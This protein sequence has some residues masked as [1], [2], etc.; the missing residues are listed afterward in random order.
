MQID[1]RDV[2]FSR[3]GSYMSLSILPPSWNQPGVTL[4]SMRNSGGCKEVFNLEPIRDGQTVSCETRCTPGQLQLRDTAGNSVEMCYEDVDLL[5]IRGRGLGL[6]LRSIEGSRPTVFRC[7]G[8]SWQAICTGNH[9]SYVFHPLTGTIEVDA[10]HRVRTQ[11]KS[12]PEEPIAK[13]W[14]AVLCGEDGKDWEMMIHDFKTTPREFEPVSSYEEAHEAATTAWVDFAAKTPPVPNHHANTAQLAMFVNYTSIIRADE[15]AVRRRTMLMSKNWMCNCWSWDHC[16]NAI[17]HARTDPDLAWDL[18]QGPFDHQDADGCLPDCYGGGGVFRSFTKPPI[19]GWT[20]SF[21]RRLNQSLLTPE[22]ICQA[23]EQ[24]SAWTNW[25]LDRRD[26]DGDG[27]PEYRHGND[28]GWDNGTVFDVGYPMVAPDLPAYLV[29]QMDELACLAEMQ[30][31]E[32]AAKMWR[33]KADAMLQRMID[34][35]WTGS[36]FLARQGFTGKRPE[37]GDCL[38]N[39]IPVILGERLPA[40]QRDALIAVLKPDGRFITEFGPATESPDSPLY[41]PDGYWRGPI[42]GPETVMVVD[43]LHRVGAVAE[44][45]E[46]ARRYCEMC[47][48]DNSMA[49]NYNAGTGV[50]LRDRA[51][52]WGSSAFLICAGYSA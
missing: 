5:R 22:R 3:A 13:P 40:P 43:G 35:L 4:R 9:T 34:E 37:Q 28:S 15:L 25:W 36:Q 7:G 50:G 19:H 18:F 49:E 27:L 16:I 26:T 52:T 48:K 46:V 1:I 14:C 11:D 42:W 20:L 30:G 31:N 21:M 47:R 33:T 51:Y 41:L 12:K 17:A 32:S 10:L 38:L 45:Q 2:P 23:Y 6:R 44:A 29:L 39:H 24:L 8:K